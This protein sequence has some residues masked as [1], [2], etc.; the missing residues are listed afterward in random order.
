MQVWARTVGSTAN[1]EAWV[2]TPTFQVNTAPISLTPD[3]DFPVP[4][5]QPVK[6]TATLSGAP[7]GVTLEYEFWVYSTSGGWTVLRNYSTSNTAKWTPSTNGTY[8]FQVWV[9]RQGSTASYDISGG[10]GPVVVAPSA[11]SVSGLTPDAKCPCPTGEALTWTARTRGG[12]AG[13]IEY[14]FWMSRPGSGWT[15]VQPY[16]NSNTFTLNPTWGDEGRYAI[17]VWARSAGSNAN[18]EA[19][20]GATFD[21]SKADLQLTTP[22]LFPAAPGTSTRWTASVSDNSVP[23][24]YSY[25]LYSQSTGTWNNV[26]PYSTTATYTWTPSASGTYALQVWARR[27]GSSAAYEIYKGT[28]YLEISNSPAEVVSLTPNVSLPATGGSSIVWTAKAIGGTAGPLRYEFWV[29]HPASGW[30]IGRTYSTSN[31]FTW[32]PS[33]PGTY[34]LQAWVRSNGSSANYEGWLGTGPVVIR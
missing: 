18:Y 6:W 15:N 9:R 32:T 19:W 1:Y 33:A 14:E 5:G 31:T 29:Y 30:S 20:R 4:H 10:A 16:S 34:M 12:S 3:A 8:S 21:V 28:S 17:Q 11:L 23:V 25:W 24:E 27:Q 13:P 26:R 22:T 7:A 2:G